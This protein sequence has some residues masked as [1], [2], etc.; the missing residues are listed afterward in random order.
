MRKKSAELGNQL[1]E[2]GPARDDGQICTTLAPWIFLTLVNCQVLDQRCI[3]ARKPASGNKV[4]G[5]PASWIVASTNMTT[6][7]WF[8]RGKILKTLNLNRTQ[9]KIMF[10]CI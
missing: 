9:C 5:S 4:T 10:T 1:I 3:M 7:S 2:S 6:L 8:C